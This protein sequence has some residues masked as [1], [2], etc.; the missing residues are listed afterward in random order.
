MNKYFSIYLNWRA[1]LI[2]ILGFITL[3]LLCDE[4]ERSLGSFFLIKAIA[5]ALALGIFRLA[6]FWHARGYFKDVEE[7]CKEE[8][9]D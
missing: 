5:V 1:D 9:E 3:I 8:D 6:K 7:I 4:S 2:A